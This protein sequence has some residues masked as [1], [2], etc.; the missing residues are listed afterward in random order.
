LGARWNDFVNVIAGVNRHAHSHLLKIIKALST[1]GLFL[2]AAQRWEQHSGQDG[3]D[4]DH[5]QQFD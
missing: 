2:G 4:R 3:N 5:H 1:L